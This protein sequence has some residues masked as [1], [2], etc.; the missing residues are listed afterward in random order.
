M[1]KPR[2]IPCLLLQNGMLVRSETF[3]LHQVIGNPLHEVKRFNEWSVDELIYLDI[4]RGGTYDE[5]REDHKV[6]GLVSPLEVLDAIAADCFVPLTF[7]GRITSIDDMLQRFQRG[8]DKIAINTA[9]LETPTLISD[10]AG[11][12]GSQAVVVSIDVKR[13]PDGRPEVFT[14]G[15]QLPTGL[16]PPTWA[17]EAEAR[18][19]GEILLNSI[20]RD[21]TGEGYDIEL[22]ASV[23]EAVAIPVIACGG[24]GRYE[25]FAPAILDGGASA[26]AAA[27][28][29]HFKELSDRN[30]KRAMRR[31]GVDV[32]LPA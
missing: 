30:A 13:H 8:A 26:V 25:D 27:N 12:F 4:S 29:F 16:D 18:G 21:G 31:S 28:I 19:A 5:S 3:S 20:D 24:V 9:A 6:K 23:T 1:L 15:G 32:R 7:G 17:V 22:I 14:R 10:A 11:R 2:L